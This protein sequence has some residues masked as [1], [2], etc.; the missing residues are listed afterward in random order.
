MG[1]IADQIFDDFFSGREHSFRRCYYAITGDKH[2]TGRIA[3]C[4][5]MMMREAQTLC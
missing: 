3:D 2:V 4:D 1:N 5:P